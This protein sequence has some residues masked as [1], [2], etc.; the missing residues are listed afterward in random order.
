ML[1]GLAWKHFLVDLLDIFNL[2]S[3]RHGVASRWPD[4]CMAG[5]GFAFCC[6]FF[7]LVLG[8]S[9]DA[10]GT[11]WCTIQCWGEP[12]PLVFH[13]MH[14]IEPFSDTPQYGF[15]SLILFNFICLGFNFIALLFLILL[16][17]GPQWQCSRLTVG[18]AFRS[19][20]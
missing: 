19:C 4:L 9:T 18:S 7:L 20:S 14:G 5:Q 13:A 12:R 6:S 11:V 10:P 1:A 8:S 3:F 15:Y 17:I 16:I 2:F